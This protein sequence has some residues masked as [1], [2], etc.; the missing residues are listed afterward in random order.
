MMTNISGNLLSENDRDIFIAQQI[1]KREY[2][3]FYMLNVCVTMM[4]DKGAK[5]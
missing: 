1:L 2:K 3:G 4:C 5:K